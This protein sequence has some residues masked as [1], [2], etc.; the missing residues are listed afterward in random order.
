MTKRETVSTSFE[1]SVQIKGDVYVAS[2]TDASTARLQF[3]TYDLMSE[4][5]QYRGGNVWW[6]H[7]SIRIKYE[8]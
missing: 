3:Y 7:I 6:A 5:V 4:E 2:P 8:G 1:E